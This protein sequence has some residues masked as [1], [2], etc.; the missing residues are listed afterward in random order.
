MSQEQ[1]AHAIDPQ[2]LR[3][4]VEGTSAETGAGFFDALVKHLARSIGTKC[5]WVT[6]W[7]PDKGRLRALSFWNGE[8]YTPD[9][10]YDITNTPCESVIESRRLVL[11]PDR[12]VYLFPKDPDLPALGAMSYM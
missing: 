2:A 6:E 9:Y 3:E 4:I 12:L 10:E 7:L 1:N 11:I 8:S 5:A